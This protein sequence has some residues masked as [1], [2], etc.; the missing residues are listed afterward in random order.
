MTHSIKAPQLFN[1]PRREVMKKYIFAAILAF[2]LSLT[3][4]A[5]GESEKL[6][7]LTYDHEG[8]TFQVRSG[9][10][11]KKDS[12]QIEVL[13]TSPLQLNLVRVKDDFCRAIVSN[14]TLIQ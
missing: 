8:I 13:E 2:S 6:L 5:A 12:F 10:C 4:Y 1:F 11:T 9:G 7:G 14:G 3:A